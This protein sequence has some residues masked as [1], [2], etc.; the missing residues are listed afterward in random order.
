METKVFIFWLDPE[1]GEPTRTL[2]IAEVLI[3]Y[4]LR[5]KKFHNH[6]STEEQVERTRK[7]LI[8][9]MADSGLLKAAVEFEENTKT[10]K[11]FY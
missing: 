3:A 9:Q 1:T 4:G 8:K 5:G 2:I 10:I 11:I 7:D 6:T